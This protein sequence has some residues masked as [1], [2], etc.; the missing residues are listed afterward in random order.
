M[1]F[2]R[3]SLPARLLAIL[4]QSEIVWAPLAPATDRKGSGRTD[5]RTGGGR[6]TGRERGKVRMSPT[7]LGRSEIRK[8]TRPTLI[9]ELS[10]T[11]PLC[12]GRFSVLS[13]KVC[14]LYYTIC[15]CDVVVVVYAQL[16]FRVDTAGYF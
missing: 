10:P 13:R 6:E 8:R 3:F 16:R 15:V 11:Y 5:G 12:S 9:W 4:S 1:P 7:Q 14:S 2:L